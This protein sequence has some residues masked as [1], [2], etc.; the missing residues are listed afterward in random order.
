MQPSRTKINHK[1]TLIIINI[2][3]K[4]YVQ[5]FYFSK[6]Q[7]FYGWLEDEW[8]TYVSLLF[9]VL[10]EFIAHCTRKSFLPSF[11]GVM[12]LSS[13]LAMTS[14]SHEIKKRRSNACVVAAA[15]TATCNSH[16]EIQLKSNV[17]L[18][19]TWK[20][21]EK[22]EIWKNLRI[23]FS[24]WWRNQKYCQ[25]FR[26]SMRQAWIKCNE[27]SVDAGECKSLDL[28]AIRE[29]SAAHRWCC[30]FFNFLV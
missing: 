24:C 11:I 28:R 30:I 29:C 5:F 21:R 3:Y 17:I 7:R 22:K 27:K 23:F 14:S 6:T 15:S 16:D 13:G 10:F 2:F 18:E 26:R 20:K 8:S 9:F 25:T 19:W 1:I 12:K 4:L